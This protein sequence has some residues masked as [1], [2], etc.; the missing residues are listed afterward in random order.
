MNL[1]NLLAVYASLCKEL[2]VPLRYP[3]SPKA[4]N[5]LANA[6]DATLLA[7]AMEWAALNETCYGEIFNITNGDVFRWSQV[8]PQIAESFGI[9]CADPQ[10]F[11][12]VEAMQDK[13][14]IWSQMVQKYGL[15]PNSL[16]DLAN[17]PFGAFIF[18][19]ENDAFFDV[20]KA[21][22]FGFHEMYLDTSEE[23]VKLWS[24]LKEQKIVPM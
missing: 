6:T 18:N 2:G 5:I 7:K 15:I 14:P 20:N 23:I 11:S 17:W 3:A 21:R 10:T 1:G 12:L 22:R 24:Y 4:Y 13:E 9:K 8:F 19:V 16:K